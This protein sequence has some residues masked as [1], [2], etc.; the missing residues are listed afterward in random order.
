MIF[1]LFDFYITTKIIA[2][3]AQQ[4]EQLTVNQLVIG[5]NPIEGATY[6]I[7][8]IKVTSLN[9]DFSSKRCGFESH[10]RPKDFY[11]VSVV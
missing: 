1:T 3:V 10:P 7:V 8:I 4:V 6:S 5:S 2:L 9:F 11:M